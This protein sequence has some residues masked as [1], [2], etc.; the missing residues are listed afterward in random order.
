MFTISKKQMH[1]M[2][3]SL[4]RQFV[5]R[6]IEFLS[7]HLPEAVAGV[8]RKILE[9]RVNSDIQVAK[10]YGLRQDADLAKWCFIS[11]VCGPQFHKSEDINGF[12]NQPLMTEASKMD[13][14][15]RSLACLLPK[16]G[17]D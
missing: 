4:E 9:E 16:K 3:T 7:Q 2:E 11:F 5:G 12:L 15:M 14:L 1:Q 17:T 8:E 6:V 13:F 10:T